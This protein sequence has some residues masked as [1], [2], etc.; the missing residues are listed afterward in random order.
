MPP[1]NVVL[2]NGVSSS[3][4]SSIARQLLD[5]LDTPY[6]HMGVDMFG[7]M[8]SETKTRALDRQAVAAVLRRTR[9]GFHRAVAAMAS[10][11]ND[12]VMDHVLSEPWRLDDCL[13]VMDG[14]N[15]VFV[16]VHCST[17]ELERRERLRG[18]RVIGAAAAQIGAVHA[19]RIYDF[20][21]DT[22]TDTAASCSA[23]IAEFLRRQPSG[24]AFDQLRAMSGR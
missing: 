6:F 15:V 10:A 23:Q 12:I 19:H 8:R 9:A 5:D 17:D 24:R 2:L 20:Q 11:G 21:V 7:A 22:S 3:G 13:A 4:K 18:D 16:G 1:G 14:I